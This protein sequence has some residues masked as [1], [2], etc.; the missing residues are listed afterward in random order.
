MDVRAQTRGHQAGQW[1]GGWGLQSVAQCLGERA[2]LCVPHIGQLQQGAVP[3]IPQIE[4]NTKCRLKSRGILWGG[5][6]CFCFFPKNRFL[7]LPAISLC[8]VFT[9]PS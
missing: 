4:V 7:I 6:F 5:F 9:W 2:T 8:P 3:K 1:S